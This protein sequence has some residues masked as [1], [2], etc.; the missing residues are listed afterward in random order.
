MSDTSSL[1]N[2]IALVTGAGRG[3]G[4][5]IALELSRRGA[6]VVLNYNKSAEA[7]ESLSAEIQAA[8]GKAA[9]FQ[10]DVSNFKQAQDLVKF[11]VDTFGDLHIL[12]NNA[13]ITRDTLI[14]MMSEEDWDAVINTNLKS[15]FNCS[16]AAVKHMMR[17]R[18]GRIINIASVAGQ[19]G[20]PGQTNYSSSKAGQIGFTKSLAREIA[21][22]NIT[23][24][25]IA[26]GFVD[27]EILD[28]MSPE[29]LEAMLKMVPLGRKGKPEEIAYAAAFLASDQAAYITGQ[30]LGV[31][32]GMA[33]M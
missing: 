21:A 16:K 4:R 11:A 13:G 9:I 14:M 30:V 29:T 20:N 2:R 28:A 27:T 15:T 23:V 6:S 33:M 26:P 3:I 22:R 19:M 25:A 1:E 18:Y 17:K 8:G 32:G 5:A 12:V 31:D 24:N 7:A 10:A